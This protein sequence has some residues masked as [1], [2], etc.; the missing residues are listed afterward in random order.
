MSICL[1]KFGQQNSETCYEVNS[2]IDAPA[3]ELGRVHRRKRHD[4]FEAP[5]LACAAYGDGFYVEAEG[6]TDILHI[7]TKDADE[8]K[9]FCIYEIF[10]RRRGKEMDGNAIIVDAEDFNTICMYRHDGEFDLDL[11]DLDGIYIT[12]DEGIKYLSPTPSNQLIVEMVLQHLV[13]DGLLTR[14][15]VD[16][17]EWKGHKE[18][19]GRRTKELERKIPP[20]MKGDWETVTVFQGSGQQKTELFRIPAESCRIKWEYEA[21]CQ[22]IGP[23]VG[24]PCFWATL[25]GRNLKFRQDIAHETYKHSGKGSSHVYASLGTY[26]F[27]VFSR[28]VNWKLTIEALASHAQFSESEG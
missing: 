20:L 24:H 22:R 26:Y 23:G 28:D 13:L 21:S 7:S 2:W 12:L 14:D 10:N 5:M 25:C 27:D 9:I 4:P 8:N 17:W 16:T 19:I 6:V 15:Q 3:R 11:F 1:K 18:K